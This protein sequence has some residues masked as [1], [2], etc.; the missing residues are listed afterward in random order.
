[1]EATAAVAGAAAAAMAEVV[2]MAAAVVV[3]AMVAVVAA[4]IREEQSQ[5]LIH[6]VDNRLRFKVSVSDLEP[7]HRYLITPGSAGLRLQ[8]RLGRGPAQLFQSRS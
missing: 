8:P 5:Q 1:M 4:D 3:A 2:A 6:G 7:Q